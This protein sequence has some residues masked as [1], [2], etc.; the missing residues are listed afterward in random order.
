MRRL[1]IILN[2][3]TGRIGTGQH[4]ARAL[5]PLRDEGLTLASGERVAIDPVLTGRDAGRLQRTAQRFGIERWSTDLD[6]CLEN[7]ED[8]VFFD[9]A[10][11]GVRHAN[12][13]RA[14]EAGKHV[15]CDKPLGTTYAEASAL[16]Q[17][18][19][20][21][22]RRNGVVMANLWLP[23]LRKLRALVD[24]GFFG[25]VLSIRGEHG[26]WIFDGHARPA[27][28]PAWNYRR[29]DGGGIVLDMMCHW[30]YMLESLF[31][32]LA[33]VTCA[34][35]TFVPDR[36]DEKATPYDATAEDAAFVLC[37]L[38]SGAMAQVCLSW[39]VRV[40]RDDLMVMQVDGTHGSA[41]VGVFDCYTQHRDQTPVL[42]WNAEDRPDVDHRAAWLPVP[43]AG[44]TGNA[45]RTQWALFLRH[46]LED[47]PF[48][49]D[50][51]MAA[52]GLEVVERCYSASG[53]HSWETLS[54]P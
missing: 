19:E 46:V 17:L 26:Y 27:Q 1:G 34:A 22:D 5:V 23:G 6:A 9:C 53:A 45:F 37:E 16:A 30:H 21:L 52:R 24:S 49:W 25:R 10:A 20:R 3:A 8:T 44:T 39:C 54:A 11:T 48:P 18:A 2:G 12:V 29:E 7:G 40:Y 50:F 41:V 42:L 51:A 33:R 28:R 47:A 14:L 31:G 4:L 13:K 32:R 35:R 38:E 15:F 43:D 36:L